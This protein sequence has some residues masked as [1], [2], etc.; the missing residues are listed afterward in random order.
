MIPR[1]GRWIPVSHGPLGD[2][3]DFRVNENGIGPFDARTD[4]PSTKSGTVPELHTARLLAILAI[5]ALV[6][7]CAA[8]GDRL[9]DVR[10]DFYAGNLEVA[11]TKIDRYAQR[12][13]GEA[14]CLKLDRAIVELAAGRHREAERILREVRDS[15]D[16]LQQKSLAESALVMTTDDT[17]AAYPGED[18]ERILIRAFLAL[19]NLMGD[20]GDAEAYGLQV[21]DLQDRIIQAGADDAGQNPKLAYKRVAFGSYLLGALREQTHANYDDAA[22]SW[23]QVVRWEPTFI[24]GHHDV[25]RAVYGRHSAPGNG[26]LYVFALV[27][28]GPYKEQADELPSTVALLIAD[29]ILSHNGRHTLPPTVAPVK[30][31]KVVVSI[32]G[33]RDVGV[34]VDGRPAGTTATVTDVGQLAVQQYQVIYPSVLARAVV[35]RVVKKGAIYAG[36]EAMSVS[37]GSLANVAMDVGGVIWEA[38]EKADTR[39]W[40]LLPNQIQVLR[41]ELPAGEH[42][43][44]LRP[45][46]SFGPSGATA[47]APV[48]IHDGRNTYLLA[49]MAEGGVIGQIS[50]SQN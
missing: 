29:R 47:Q 27:G 11:S 4:A 35:R 39:C 49:M 36:K 46:V 34:V 15:F 12:Y 1:Q 5:L 30:V 21:A 18:Y 25:D 22:R 33:I 50:T 41:V 32:N 16:D 48:Q 28:R 42:R 14:D 10:N 38:T 44:A 31:P 13:R 20:G 17:S 7:G 40:G 45:N 43:V 8:H 23:A 19:A 9:R 3:P 6:G 26:V 37:N 24:P 2:C